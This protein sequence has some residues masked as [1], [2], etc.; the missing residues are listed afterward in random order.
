MPQSVKDSVKHILNRVTSSEQKDWY[1]VVNH[2]TDSTVPEDTTKVYIY[3]EI[4][5]WGVTASDFVEEFMQITTPKIH[6][7]INSPGGQMFDGLAIYNALKSHPS[8]VTAIVDA[9]AASAASF[10]AMGGDKILAARNST[11]MIHDASGLV[12]GNAQD[13][14]Q[15]ADLLDKMSN[16]IA[17]IYSQRAGG[18]PEEWRAM[19]Q[20]ETWYTGQEAVDAKLVDALVEPEDTGSGGDTS[21]A[22]NRWDLS[23]FNYAGRAFA[24]SPDKVRELVKSTSNNAKGGTV[25]G[26]AA[27]GTKNENETPETPEGQTPKDGEKP[28]E[29]EGGGTTTPP[30]Q[31]PAPAAGDTTQP[32]NKAGLVPVLVN[33]AS[34]EVP[35]PVAQR[36][37]TLETFQTETIENNRK[38][39][40]K[41]LAAGPRPKIAA[42]QIEELEAFALSL[43]PEQYD[44]WCASMDKAPASQLFAQHGGSTTEPAAGGT[45]AQTIA[46]RIEVLEGI[47]D[48]HKRTGTPQEQIENMPSWKELQTLKAQQQPA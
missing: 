46:D 9:L 21:G 19:M 30:E 13:M 12:Y 18:T 24:P 40:V 33:G 48:H 42:S 25:G 20:A 11:M 43:N 8:E 17:D 44:K 22:E 27:T 41:S 39:F 26:T 36:L 31:P 10:I 6:V 14:H 7:H 35:G 28:K 15:M 29:G 47:V 32:E 23:I 1:R 3:D 34:F 38:N 5:Y 4:G 37:T 16:N 2:S 45:Q